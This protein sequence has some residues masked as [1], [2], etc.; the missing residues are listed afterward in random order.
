MQLQIE[1]ILAF[2]DNYIWVL[3]DNT[4]RTVVCVDPGEAAPVRAYCQQHQLELSAIL[5]THH[6]WDHTGG[7]KALNPQPA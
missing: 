1:P 3:I 2:S 5:I 4:T 6:H 7:I